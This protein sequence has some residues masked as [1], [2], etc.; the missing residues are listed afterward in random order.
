MDNNPLARALESVQRARSRSHRPG[1]C[2]LECDEVAEVHVTILVEVKDGAAVGHAAARSREALD[3]PEKARQ[4][5]VAV[6]IRISARR[7]QGERLLERSR[8]E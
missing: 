4:I 8:G 7:S 2:R 5:D 6:S 3:N 1:E